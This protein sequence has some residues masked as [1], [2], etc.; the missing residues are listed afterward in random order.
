MFTNICQNFLIADDGLRKEFDL[1]FEVIRNN[2]IDDREVNEFR[3]DFLQTDNVSF[4]DHGL[5]H[6]HQ[7]KDLSGLLAQ[8]SFSLDENGIRSL[9]PPSS[10]QTALRTITVSHN[11]NQDLIGIQNQIPNQT[12]DMEHNK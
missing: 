6:R 7:E 1:L 5:A 4:D 12:F 2:K 3:N 11:T 8:P 10:F 9:N